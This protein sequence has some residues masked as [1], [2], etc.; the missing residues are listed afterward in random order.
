MNQAWLFLLIL[1]NLEINLLNLNFLPR[2]CIK[3]IMILK[4]YQVGNV[5]VIKF[6]RC[7]CWLPWILHAFFVFSQYIQTYQTILK[8][9]NSNLS[10]TSYTLVR[11]LLM[12]HRNFLTFFCSS[13]R[14]TVFKKQVYIEA[15]HLNVFIPKKVAR[16][17]ICMYCVQSVIYQIYT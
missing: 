14:N 6:F 4:Q 3:Q 7:F 10:T 12:I 5:F 15:M 13:C 2:F 11:S 16:I 8:L 17:F 1:F 9:H